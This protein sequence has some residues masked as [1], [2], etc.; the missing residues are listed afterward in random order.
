MT[1]RAIEKAISTERHSA[2]RD[3]DFLKSKIDDLEFK[4]AAEKE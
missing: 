4:L 3:S 1:K 2:K